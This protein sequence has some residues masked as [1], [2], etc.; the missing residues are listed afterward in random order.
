MTQPEDPATAY[1][2]GLAARLADRGLPEGHIAEILAG[3]AGAVPQDR[4]PAGAL[5][6]A[7]A[8]AARLTPPPAADER[9]EIWRWSADTYADAALLD[10]FG[11]EGWELEGVDDAGRFV[12]RRDPERPRPWEYR[13]T[14][15]PGPAAAP[16]GTAGWLLRG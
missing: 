14:V 9:V 15:V 1:W 6:A 7:E 16:P 10:R 3:L 5:G 8:L 12:C 2:D 11:A 13:R 4:G